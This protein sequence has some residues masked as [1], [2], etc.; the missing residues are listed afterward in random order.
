MEERGIEVDGVVVASRLPAEVDHV[1]VAEFAND[2][3][4]GAFG[5]VQALRDVLDRGV[6]TGG[7]M[8]EDSP[9]G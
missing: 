7:Q 2:A 6:G 5:E 9:L 1:A 4:D 8:E 3:P